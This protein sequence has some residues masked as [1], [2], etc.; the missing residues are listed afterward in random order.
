MKKM[1]KMKKEH[2]YAKTTVSLIFIGGS[3]STSSPGISASPNPTPSCFMITFWPIFFHYK[4]PT[5]HLGH[6]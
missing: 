3:T 6:F 4:K 1:K 2:F 5:N